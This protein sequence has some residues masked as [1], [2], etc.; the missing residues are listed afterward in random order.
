VSP[1]REV[2]KSFQKL[3]TKL[4]KKCKLATTFG[5]GP[6]FLHS[7]G[8]LHKGDAGNGLFIQFT[9]EFSKDIAIPDEPTEDKSS[10]SFG[11]LISAQAMGD[12]Q[13][14]INN[15]RKVI[16]L[17]LKGDIAEEILNLTNNL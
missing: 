16:T 10:I 1:N 2:T 14:L 3:R 8:Q 17:H 4:Q 12:R 13:A 6:R 11:V 15:D 7:T 9:S 5:Y